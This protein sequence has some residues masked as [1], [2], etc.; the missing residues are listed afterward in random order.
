MKC[1]TTYVMTQTTKWLPTTYLK[2]TFVT[3]AKINISEGQRVYNPAPKESHG[4]SAGI[5]NVHATSTDG[6]DSA[7]ACDMRAA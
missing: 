4:K 7:D 6:Q 1:L 2:K 5:K 3:D